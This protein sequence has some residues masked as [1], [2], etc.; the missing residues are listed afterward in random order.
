MPEKR[1]ASRFSK[2]VFVNFTNTPRQENLQMIEEIYNREKLYVSNQQNDNPQ[3]FNEEMAEVT[4]KR[5]ADQEERRKRVATERGARKSGNNSM[6]ES[7]SKA[8]SLFQQA[9]EARV[10][11]FC[12][13]ALTL[14]T[15]NA[16][17]GPPLPFLQEAGA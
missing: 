16:N 5:V 6:A 10:R 17:G 2:R 13:F 12:V 7:F 8:T 14:L 1:I 11:E 3:A 15:E 9:A 4:K